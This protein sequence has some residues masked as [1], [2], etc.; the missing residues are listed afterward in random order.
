MKQ[1]KSLRKR[2]LTIHPQ[3]FIVVL[4]VRLQNLLSG[5]SEHER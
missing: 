4:W 1:S 2:Q 3:H 5:S